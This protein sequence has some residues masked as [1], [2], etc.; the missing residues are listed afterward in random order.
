MGKIYSAVLTNILAERV[1][2]TLGSAAF[3]LMNT[4]FRRR[5]LPALPFLRLDVRTSLRQL[6]TAKHSFRYVTETLLTMVDMV[7]IECR[8]VISWIPGQQALTMAKKNCKLCYVCSIITS[9]RIELLS[10][11]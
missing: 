1:P 5:C 6:E 9:K 11:S 10:P 4:A 3:C 7:L 2:R 8:C